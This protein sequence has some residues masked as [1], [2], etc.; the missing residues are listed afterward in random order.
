LEEIEGLNYEQ[1]RIITGVLQIETAKMYEIMTKFEKVK[2]FHIETILDVF[3][4]SK[5]KKLGFS[6]I[7]ISYSPDKQNIFAVLLTKSLVGYK[8]KN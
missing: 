3:C 2:V 7:P 5:I 8:V 6:R 1:G 4:V